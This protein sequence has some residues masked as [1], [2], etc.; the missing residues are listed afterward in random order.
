VADIFI[1]YKS[2]RRAAAEHLAEILTD[3]G[4]SVWWDY[5]LVLGGDFGAQIEKELRAAKAVIVLWCS[6]SVN[7]EW[8]REEAT[9]AKHLDKIIPACVERVELPLGFSLKQTLDLSDWD[10]APQSL[11]L[12]QLLRDVSK[13]VDQPPQPNLEG[14]GRTERAWRRFGAPP[15]SRFALIDALEPETPPSILAGAQPTNAG[16]LPPVADSE[17]ALAFVDRGRACLERWNYDD[18]IAAFEE[19]IRRDPDIAEELG[20]DFSEALIARGRESLEEACYDEAI[21]DFEEAIRRDPD[22]EE[23]LT[24]S[25]VEALTNRGRDFLEREDYDDAIEDFEEAISRD[26]DREEELTSSIVEA[27]TNRGRASLE[28]Q[29]YNNAVQDFSEAVKRD[30]DIA[31]KLQSEIVQAIAAALAP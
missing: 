21:S 20:S 18:A 12:V 7:S 1:S 24:S 9:L 16:A 6:L 14:L 5:G 8:V 23:E 29:D 2:E 19:A 28:A 11:R 17:G 3:Y 15:L 4:Y 26:P 22:S 30:P 13:K 25:I 27:L 31:E 10:G